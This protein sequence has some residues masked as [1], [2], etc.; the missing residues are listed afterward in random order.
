KQTNRK[1]VLATVSNV[2]L[3]MLTGL[4]EWSFLTFIDVFFIQS[5]SIFR[6]YW[7]WRFGGS[8]LA[9]VIFFFA[10]LKSKTL[11]FEF[12]PKGLL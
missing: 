5:E 6:S 1:M 12:Y 9:P 11:F 8:F 4:S 2:A 7:I 10:Y 3:F